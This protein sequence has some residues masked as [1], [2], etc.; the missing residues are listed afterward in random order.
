MAEQLDIV[1]VR[2]GPTLWNAA[3]RFQGHTDTP[4]SPETV[5]S[6]T[7]CRLPARFVDYSMVSSPLERT[8]RTAQLL[9]ADNLVREP[10]I[11]EMYYGQWQGKTRGDIAA[12]LGSELALL[13]S[14]GIDFRPAGGESPRELRTRLQAWLAEVAAGS[15]PVVAF[16]HKGVIHMAIAMATGWDLMSKRPYKLDWRSAHCFGL[17]IE[18]LGLCVKEMNIPFG[19]TGRGV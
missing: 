6:L 3:G 5:A 10:R 17:D 19:S 1:L 9:G 4:L 16:T 14:R 13:E 2:H 15:R 18:T 12:E 7:G 11:M 8:L